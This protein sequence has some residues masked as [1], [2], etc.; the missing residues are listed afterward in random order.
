IAVGTGAAS[1]GTF[2]GV[3]P[4]ASLMVAKALRAD[5]TGQTSWVIDAMEWA[6]TNGADIINLSL[7]SEPTDG[8][9]PA[10]LAVDALSE[11]T[12]ALFV[13]ASGN[14]FQD[15]HVLAPGTAS[16]ALT[17]GAVNRQDVIPSFSNRGPRRGDAAV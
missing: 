3:A 12:G 4:G 2:T 13:V 15:Q 1:D 8:T 5:G 6:A 7:G 17:V 11:Q 9:D 16:S 10:S 14:D